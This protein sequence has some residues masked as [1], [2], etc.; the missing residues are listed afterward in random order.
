M[1]VTTGQIKRV[2]RAMAEMRLPIA[3]ARIYPDGTVELLTTAEHEHPPGQVRTWVDMVDLTDA[4][5][6][7]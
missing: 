3:G 5:T 1:S 6:H 7:P 4:Q 2:A